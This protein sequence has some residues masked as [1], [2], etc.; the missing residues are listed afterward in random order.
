MA[1][2]LERLKKRIKALE[3]W[4]DENEALGGPE[5][6][7]DTFNYLISR[8]KQADQMQ[9]HLNQLQTYLQGFLNE[10]ELM[11][12]W[13]EWIKEKENAVQEQS[14]EKVPPL[15]EAKDGEE[16]GEEDTKGSEASEEGKKD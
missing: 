1:A 7:L 2:N 14:S 11:E 3:E 16:V 12:D 10:K 6:T 5:G 8:V 15:E 4:T 13:N 9:Q